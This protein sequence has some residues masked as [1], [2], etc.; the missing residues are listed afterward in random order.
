MLLR[1]QTQSSQIMYVLNRM[2]T[3][4]YAFIVPEGNQKAS[5]CLIKRPMLSLHALFFMSS[6][7]H[8]NLQHASLS[9][10]L[11]V[12]GS[13]QIKFDDVKNNTINLIDP[14]LYMNKYEHNR[15]TI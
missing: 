7:Q 12:L 1:L 11:F 9:S 6:K 15:C 4:L 14:K 5:R 3:A 8:K 13:K 2:Y 10:M